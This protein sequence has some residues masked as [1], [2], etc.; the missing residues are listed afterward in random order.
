MYM[1]LRELALVE[2]IVFH[3]VGFVAYDGYP[4][5]VLATNRLQLRRRSLLA[6]GL[7]LL[8]RGLQ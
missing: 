7:R 5:K 4:E 2:H 3:P 6:W 8:P 1:T